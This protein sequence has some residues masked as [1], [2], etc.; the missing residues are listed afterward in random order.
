ML[1]LSFVSAY[2]CCVMPA[3]SDYSHV[4]GDAQASQ[5]IAKSDSAYIAYRIECGRASDSYLHTA[6]AHDI[7]CTT[8]SCHQ[9]T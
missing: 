1:L 6:P 9:Y 8:R 2:A 5:H 4:A 7:L 3:A